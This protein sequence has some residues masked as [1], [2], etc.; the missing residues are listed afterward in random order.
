MMQTFIYLRTLRYQLLLN[1][2]HFLKSITNCTNLYSIYSLLIFTSSFR[3]DHSQSLLIIHFQLN[4]LCLLHCCQI[5]IRQILQRSFPLNQ[6]YLVLYYHFNHL[7][8]YY[9][10]LFYCYYFYH[11]YQTLWL[12]LNFFILFFLIIDCGRKLL[13]I[14]VFP[15]THLMVPKCFLIL[16]ALST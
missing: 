1:C 6:K 7:I 11:C 16:R 9:Y 2:S 8:Y 15:S 14:T 3:T 4:C 12:E 13:Q 5:K 10:I